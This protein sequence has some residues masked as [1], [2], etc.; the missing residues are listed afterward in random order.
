MIWG[1]IAITYLTEGA[2]NP[3][4][5]E[6]KVGKSSQIHKPPIKSSHA[7]KALRLPSTMWR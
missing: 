1:D 2:H 5:T 6:Q 3:R 7:L 4:L